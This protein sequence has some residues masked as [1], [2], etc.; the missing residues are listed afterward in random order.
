MNSSSNCF[1]CFFLTARAFFCLRIFLIKFAW[2]SIGSS[3]LSIFCKYCSNSSSSSW[4]SSSSSSS[5]Y[6]FLL[7]FFGGGNSL[8]V[9]FVFFPPFLRGFCTIESP[10]SSSSTAWVAFF[11]VVLFDAVPPPTISVRSTISGAFVNSFFALF[12]GGAAGKGVS[13]GLKNNN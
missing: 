1:I 12:V 7:L 9:S 6:A 8:A 10:L 4:Y 5:S 13:V 11:F 3:S 2:S